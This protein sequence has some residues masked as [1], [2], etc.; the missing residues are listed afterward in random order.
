M[1]DEL[2]NFYRGEI[3]SQEHENE[4][5]YF[6]AFSDNDCTLI[7]LEGYIMGIMRTVDYTYMFD[8]HTRNCFGMPDPNDS[9]VVLK[10]A[11]IFKL[12]EYFNK[13]SFT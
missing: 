11:D 5:P 10:F 12:E 1:G 8:S 9:A 6:H 2:Q 13:S 4:V 3:V 7:T